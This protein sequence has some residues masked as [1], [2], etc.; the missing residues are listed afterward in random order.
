MSTSPLGASVIPGSGSDAAVLGW[1]NEVLQ[2]GDNFLRAQQ[3]Y[4][5]IGET[6]RATMGDADDLSVLK[7][8]KLSVT[9]SNRIGKCFFDL[10]SM[11]TDIRP[12]WEYRTSNP[13]YQKQ[14]EILGK[15][16]SH[17]YTQRQ[18]DVRLTEAVMWHLVGGTGWPHVY[19][20]PVIQDQQVKGLDPRDVLPIRPSTYGSI[21]TAFGVCLREENTVNYLR[22]RYP[23]K[24]ALIRADRDASQSTAAQTSRV[25]RLLEQ[26][27]SPFWSYME[28]Q[29][30]ARGMP[31]I[32]TADVFTIYL[33]DPA[34]NKSGFPVAVG[35]FDPQGKPAN[36]WSYLVQPG[37][38][39]YPRKRCIIATRTAVLYDGPSIYWH[40]LFPVPKL[41][42]R[43]TPWS[44][45]GQAPLWDALP[46]QQS[47]RRVL[48]GID[49]HVDKVLEPGVIADK[50]SVSRSDLDAINTRRPGMKLRHNPL[51]GKGIAIDRDPPLGQEIYNHRDWLI[52]EIDM[53]TGVRDLTQLLRLN[54]MPAADTMDKLIEAMTPSV[55]MA[56][57][58][59]EAFMREFAMI[60][61][62]NFAQF[63]TLPLRLAILGP[64]GVT[65]EDFDFDPDTFIPDY[66]H[67][68]DFDES[69]RV[70][71]REALERGPLPR[72][73]RGHEFMRQITYHV[74][75]GSQL[76]SSEIE[77]KMMYLQLARAGLVDRWTLLEVLG[78]PNVG[79]PPAGATTITDRLM[80]EQQMGLGMQVNPAGRKASGQT[81]P[82][83]VMK[84]ST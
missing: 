40:G 66:M 48:R 37:D 33:A 11:Y 62:S 19:W 18:I 54:Q 23:S 46:L 71:T 52:N 5:K 76:A 3:G 45:F 83:L 55:R 36:N 21:Q 10:A 72:Y 56:S 82:R 25:G 17:W 63:Y 38:P 49:D 59:I 75:P 7:L 28:K 42:L 80:A 77:R 22:R 35:E 67:E 60:V 31:R 58:M 8:A 29:G 70:P 30:M 68:S 51:A 47:L 74:A 14:A 13:R 79:E 84:E 50:N 1:I 26:V 65:T 78:I 32:P 53:I 73:Q 12:F 44:W 41:T 16:S 69:G 39:L 2:E 81:T 61:A 27:T 64:D 34:V 43:P 57:R 9:S 4:N 15:L 24:A 20:D 6:I